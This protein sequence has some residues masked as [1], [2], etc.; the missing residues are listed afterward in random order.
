MTQNHMTRWIEDAEGR[1]TC[2]MA[3]WNQTPAP[4]DGRH[5]HLGE[6]ILKLPA[7]IGSGAMGQYLINVGGHALAYARHPLHSLHH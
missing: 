2:E 6:T 7:L 4:T 5:P 1:H 3:I